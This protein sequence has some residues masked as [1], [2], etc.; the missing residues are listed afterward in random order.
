MRSIAQDKPPTTSIKSLSFHNQQHQPTKARSIINMFVSS[1]ALRHASRRLTT[2][3]FRTVSSAS[4]A[5]NNSS[6][7]KEEYFRKALPLLFASGAAAIGATQFTRVSCVQFSSQKVHFWA[8]IFIATL[9]PKIFTCESVLFQLRHALS[10]YR[11]SI[12][13]F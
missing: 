6:R 13:R 4:K 11:S 3:S 7:A 2:T 10:L 8:S 12:A 1:T 5:S 9:S